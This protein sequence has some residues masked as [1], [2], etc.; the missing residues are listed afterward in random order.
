MAPELSFNV[1]STQ[2][3]PFAAAP[4][5]AFK[6]RI[7]AAE[8][9]PIH[10]VLL[11]CQIH[12]EVTRRRYDADEQSKLFDLFGPPQDWSRTLRN[13]L[14]THSHVSVPGFTG[15]TVVDLPVPCTYDFNVATVKYFDALKDDD[16]P[17][18]L[19]FSGTVFYASGQ[20]T[21]QVAQIPWEKEATYRF[22]VRV[23]RE[24]MD[25]YHP[26]T[27]W[28]HVHKD[29]F[30]RLLEYKRRRAL[31]TWEQTI[32]SLLPPVFGN[33]DQVVP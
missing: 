20:N 14:W 6:L 8:G 9:V 18:C 19:L 13:M 21:L 17:L 32:E 25:H 27:A 26:N 33:S 10:S 1:E 15:S 28:L 5:L 24:M 7:E 31:P 22:P 2:A 23:W 3:V 11:R 4:T 12:L 29:V 16:V 30:D